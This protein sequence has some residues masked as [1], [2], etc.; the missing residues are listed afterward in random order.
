MPRSWN[1]SW[2]QKSL[3]T[4]QRGHWD[5]PDLSSGSFFHWFFWGAFPSSFK[6]RGTTALANQD[7]FHQTLWH[8]CMTQ[9]PRFWGAPT[10]LQLGIWIAAGNAIE[11]PNLLNN[12]HQGTARAP[13]HQCHRWGTD[14]VC[15]FS[16]TSSTPTHLFWT[17]QQLFQF[18]GRSVHSSGTKKSPHTLQKN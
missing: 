10:V 2:L 13:Q 3:K 15:H 17:Q 8:S 14:S 4:L 1:D 11:A 7:L 9:S 5:L 18:T 12:R 16:L 6:R